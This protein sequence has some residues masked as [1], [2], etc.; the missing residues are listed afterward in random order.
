MLQ[1]YP[2]LEKLGSASEPRVSTRSASKAGFPLALGLGGHD[3]KVLVRTG[4]LGHVKSLGTRVAFWQ[5]IPGEVC[6]LWW[7]MALEAVGDQQRKPK[8]CLTSTSS[9]CLP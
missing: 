4:S 9:A 1:E 6:G 7:P 8:V 3:Q 2:T 5:Y